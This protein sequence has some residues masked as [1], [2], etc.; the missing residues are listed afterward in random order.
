M[1]G[2][3][4][5]MDQAK[6][7]VRAL[8]LQPAAHSTRALP[9]LC[10]E[11]SSASITVTG[12]VVLALRERGGASGQSAPALAVARVCASSAEPRVC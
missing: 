9:T 8:H 12:V 6:S 1:L 4:A 10:H 2:I 7:T 3:V 5:C 11:C